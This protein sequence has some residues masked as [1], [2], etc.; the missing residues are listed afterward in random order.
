[1]VEEVVHVAS[2][3]PWR[4][5]VDF[6]FSEG[7]FECEVAGGTRMMEKREFGLRVINLWT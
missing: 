6:K 5:R 4:G 7:T 1:M 2:A 3:R